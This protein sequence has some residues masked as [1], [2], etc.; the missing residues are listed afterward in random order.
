MRFCTI[1][2]EMAKFRGLQSRSSDGSMTKKK[3]K[4]GCGITENW[5]NNQG[6]SAV[7]GFE[8]TSAILFAAS[9]TAQNG[10]FLG[11]AG[12]PEVPFGDSARRTF[13]LICS[14]PERLQLHEPLLQ[15]AHS[16]AVARM[17]A[18]A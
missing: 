2:A 9:C 15:H 8:M 18:R 1:D 4:M 7:A 6:M 3:A 17:P 12:T 16:F 14:R 5:H 13:P 10:S 11:L